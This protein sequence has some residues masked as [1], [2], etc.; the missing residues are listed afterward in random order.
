MTPGQADAR[1]VNYQHH[2]SNVHQGF[3]KGFLSPWYAG[4]SAHSHGHR[5]SSFSR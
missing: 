3:G 5:T 2:H 1:Y 4:P